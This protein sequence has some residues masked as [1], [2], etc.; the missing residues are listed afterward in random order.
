MC[1]Y[2]MV[3]ENQQSIMVVDQLEHVLRGTIFYRVGAYKNQ[4][5]KNTGKEDILNMPE[6]AYVGA[7][8]TNGNLTGCA[9]IALYGVPNQGDEFTYE[10]QLPWSGISVEDVTSDGYNM[11]TP[12][13]LQYPQILRNV[14]ANFVGR[15]RAMQ[16]AELGNLKFYFSMKGITHAGFSPDV[17]GLMHASSKVLVQ[18]V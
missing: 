16:M 1:K 11:I 6:N 18:K 8:L 2:K 3:T 5:Y 7:K 9:V 15:E 12:I 17:Y 13:H 10:H 14:R 4:L